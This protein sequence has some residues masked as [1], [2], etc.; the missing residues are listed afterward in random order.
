MLFPKIG[1]VL[2]L[3]KAEKP[4]ER[5]SVSFIILLQTVVQTV[6]D[7]KASFQKRYPRKRMNQ[8]EKYDSFFKEVLGPEIHGD[9]L[10]T[11]LSL[12]LEKKI[13]IRQILPNDAVRLAE[14][15]TLLITDI[16]IELEDGTIGN[17]E[18]QKIGYAF[19]GQRAACYSADLLLRQYKRVKDRRKKNF[20]YRDLKKVYTIVL[21]EKSTKEFHELPDIYLHHSRQVFRTGLEIDKNTIQYMIEELEEEL[22][23]EKKHTEAE[24]KRAEEARRKAEAASKKAEAEKEKAEKMAYEKDAEIASLKEQIRRLQRNRGES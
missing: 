7:F 16:V 15:W 3:S 6:F 24:K 22:K 17:L 5:F 4:A 18:I 1:V 20:T 9:R 21:F 23:A 10:E 14:E 11:F 12:L 13:K 2:S 19:P 8:K